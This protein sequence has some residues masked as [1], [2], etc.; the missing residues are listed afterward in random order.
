VYS[1]CPTNSQSG[2]HNGLYAAGG[3]DVSSDKLSC[4][5][6]CCWPEEVTKDLRTYLMIYHVLLSLLYTEDGTGEKAFVREAV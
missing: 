6:T 4:Y 1:T 3:P 5:S 2:E